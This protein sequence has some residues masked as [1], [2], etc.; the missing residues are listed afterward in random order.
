MVAL[1][2]GRITPAIAKLALAARPADQG[3]YR[4]TNW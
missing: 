4:T 3:A 1:G 2:N